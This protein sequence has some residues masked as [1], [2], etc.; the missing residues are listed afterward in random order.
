MNSSKRATLINRLFALL[1]R[2]AKESELDAELSFHIEMKTR[3]NIEA[4]MAPRDARNAALRSFGN[5]GLIRED[6]R[7]AWGFGAAEQLWQDG[8]YAARLFRKNPGFTVVVVL[9][10][11]LGI[12]ANTA[13]FSVVHGILLRP[14]PYH[15]ASRLVRVYQSNARFGASKVA[16]SIPDI[17]DANRLSSLFDGIACFQASVATLTGTGEP[18][19]LVICEV[20]NSFFTVLGARPLIGRTFVEGDQGRD[21]LVIVSYPLWKRVFVGDESAI[22]RP[23]TLD[24]KSRTVIGVMPAGFDTPQS[25]VPAKTEVWLPLD[26]DTASRAARNVDAVGRLKPATTLPQARLELDSISARLGQAYKADSGWTFELLPLRDSIVA[27]VRTSIL[28][29]FAA[30]GLVL[31]ITCANVAGLLLARGAGRRREIALRAAIGAGRGRI[32]RQLLTE[33]LFLAATGGLLGLVAAFWGANILR[34]VAPKDIPRLEEIT[35]SLPVLIFNVGISLAAGL[36]FD[37]VPAL[38]GSKTSLSAAF[39][40]GGA[41]CR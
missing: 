38:Q 3:E 5:A 8:C 25:E 23:V 20:S 16:N 34:A 21:D 28:I 4:G 37:V 29:I 32:I 12:G 41:V 18:E 27:G 9:T 19:Q 26:K 7:R 10:L 36:L 30:V 22:G 6:T 11:A 35:I 24:G 17:E 33:T 31:L 39:K 14:L 40:D 1:K 13:I 15:D 2:P